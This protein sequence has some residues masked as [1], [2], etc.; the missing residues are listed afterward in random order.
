LNDQGKFADVRT[1][2]IALEREGGLAVLDLSGEHDLNTAEPL[3]ERLDSLIEDG[4]P[5]VVDLSRATF[6][7]SAIL[8]ILLDARRRAHE[9]GLGF[10]MANGDGADPVAR[11]LEVTGLSSELPVHSTRDGAISDARDGPGRPG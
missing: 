11:V 1:G 7:G 4:V 5:V 10:A 2:E 6:V 9:A 8:G 3:R